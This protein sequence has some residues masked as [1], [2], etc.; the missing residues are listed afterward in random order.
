LSLS[1]TSLGDRLRSEGYLVDYAI[2]GEE[3]VEK[4]STLPVDLIV[5]DIMIPKRNGFMVMMCAA[6]FA[7]PGSV[8]AYAS[9]LAASSIQQRRKCFLSSG[10]ARSRGR[11]SHGELLINEELREERSATWSACRAACSITARISSLSR[12]E[13]ANSRRRSET[14]TRRPRMH[15]RPPHFPSSIVVLFG[16][17]AMAI[18]YLTNCVRSVG[19]AI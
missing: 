15:G 13:A 5:L 16:G 4:V 7:R 11:K 9:E 8:S 14:R 10:S 18:L 19:R 6:I 3:K 12:S 2:D 1:F 17:L